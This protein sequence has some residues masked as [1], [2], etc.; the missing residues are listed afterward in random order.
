MTAR[1][2]TR[3]QHLWSALLIIGSV[4][5]SL[6]FACATPFAAF[7]ALAALILPRNEALL[8]ASG[9][10][11]ANQAVG[12]AFLHYPLTLNCF[13]WGAAV[14]VGILV[15]ALAAQEADGRLAGVGT[16]AVSIGGFL[17]AFVAHQGFLFLIA[18]ALLGGTEEFRPAIIGQIFA[19][20]TATFLGAAALVHV[21][22]RFGF[23]S[24]ALPR[25]VLGQ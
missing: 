1:L 6:G 10:W 25:S 9:V 2:S 12:F 4:A 15:A 11:L 3:Q 8:A 19:V 21:A 22:A 20:N 7:A 17:A 18:A 5:L 14:G 16:I 24:V 23:V 13:A